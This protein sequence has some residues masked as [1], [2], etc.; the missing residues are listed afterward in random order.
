MALSAEDAPKKALTP[1]QENLRR[2]A[3]E[4][5]NSHRHCD[6][7][8]PSKCD[9]YYNLIEVMQDLA[10]EV[11]REERAPMICGHPVACSSGGACSACVREARL[12]AEA[13]SLA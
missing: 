4:V 3:I 2:L 8:N 12:L 6:V 11:V 13:R 9:L 7:G 5:V 10:Y 1:F